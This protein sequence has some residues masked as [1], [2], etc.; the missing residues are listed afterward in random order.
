V[1]TALLEEGHVRGYYEATSAAAAPS[2]A[3]A[4]GAEHARQASERVESARRR[5]NASD[6]IA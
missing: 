1:G 5:E 2:G 4:A 3:A 6:V